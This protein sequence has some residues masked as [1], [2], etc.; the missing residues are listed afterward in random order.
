VRNFKNVRILSVFRGNGKEKG[1]R[2]IRWEGTERQFHLVRLFSFPLAEKS[3]I[4][5]IMLPHCFT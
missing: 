2:Q 4:E 3:E 1:L 5:V